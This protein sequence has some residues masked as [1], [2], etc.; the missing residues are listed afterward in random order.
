MSTLK[1][2]AAEDNVIN[3]K[4]IQVQLD[5]IDCNYDIVGDGVQALENANKSGYD[6]IL[7][8]L[9]MPKMNGPEVVSE[10]RNGNGPSKSS[11]IVALTANVSESDQHSSIESGMDLFVDKPLSSAKVADI[12]KAYKSR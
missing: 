10:I 1:I 4:L 11:L 3:Q 12:I 9:Q 6:I 2:L 5:K 8:D 7:M